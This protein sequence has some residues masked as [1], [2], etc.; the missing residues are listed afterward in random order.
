MK[1]KEIIKELQKL[2]NYGYV[3][4]ATKETFNKAKEY[5][6]EM[7]EDMQEFYKVYNGG[8]FFG[9]DFACVD[10]EDGYTF[11]KLND[12]EFKEMYQIPQNIIVFCD[13]GYG[14]YVGYDTENK[15]FIQV[16]PEEDEENWQVFN[17]FTDFLKEFLDISKELIEDGTFEPLR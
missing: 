13:T 11:D 10:E 12:G 8:L 6:G 16:N 4:N 7:P 1:I 5:F 9:H 2:E 15:N 14:D 17:T 3:F